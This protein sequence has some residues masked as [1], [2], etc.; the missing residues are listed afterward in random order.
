MW[1]QL[2]KLAFSKVYAKVKKGH[3]NKAQK[4]MHDV[5]NSVL[6]YRKIL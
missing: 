5:Q 2:R 3:M 1:V 6:R 4:L